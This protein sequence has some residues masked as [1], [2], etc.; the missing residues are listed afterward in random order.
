[1]S[2]QMFVAYNLFELS[3]QGEGFAVSH[4]IGPNVRILGYLVPSSIAMFCNTNHQAG[5]A[6]FCF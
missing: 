6:L 1:M 3:K 5:C 4:I 2:C